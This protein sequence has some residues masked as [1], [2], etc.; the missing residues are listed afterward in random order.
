[1]INAERS[2]LFGTAPE[3]LGNCFQILAEKEFYAKDDNDT[4]KVK[5]LHD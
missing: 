3:M 5:V 4:F 2:A 1:M